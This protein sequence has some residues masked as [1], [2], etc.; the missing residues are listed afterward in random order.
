MPFNNVNRKI[1]VGGARSSTSINPRSIKEDMQESIHVLNPKMQAMQSMFRWFGRG[2]KPQGHKITTVQLHGFDPYD[3]VSAVTLGGAANLTPGYERYARLTIDQVSR[4]STKD[5]MYYQPQDSFFIEKTKQNVEVVMT[6][7]NAIK[8]NGAEITLPAALTG[9]TTGL[10]APGTIVVKTKNPGLDILPFTASDVVYMGRTIH[11]SQKIE[12]QGHEVDMLYDCNFVE[13]KECTFQMTEDQKN[14]IKIK[15]KMP[16]WERQ[17]QMTL[18]T[19]TLSNEMTLLF[20]ERA[21]DFSEVGRPK[22]WM[23]GL[24]NAIK[25]NVAVYN[26]DNITDWEV[27][28]AHIMEDVAFN[29]CPNGNNKLAFAGAKFIT[30]FNLYFATKRQLN[31]EVI[32]GPMGL[33]I[34]EYVFGDN[35]LTLVCNEALARNTNMAHW[36]FIIDP[37]EADVRIVKDYESRYYQ[38]N[39][40]RDLKF[41]TEWQGTIAWNIEQAHAL[42]RTA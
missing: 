13:H 18:E 26:P 36:C 19:F 9:N 29:H 15:H 23:N 41:M 32:K 14:L 8:M 16:D 35:K 7:T 34:S 40:E 17:Q 38:N 30:N 20:G 1:A 25:T 5:I 4:P 10:S 27:F 28:M 3:Y 24:Y 6:P 37:K 12:A 11:E 2:P 31:N 22:Y 39:D 21:S 33:N 42:I